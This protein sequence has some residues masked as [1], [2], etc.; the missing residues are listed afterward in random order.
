VIYLTHSRLMVESERTVSDSAAFGEELSR[1]VCAQ[2]L[3]KPA[4]YSLWHARHESGMGMVASARWR[5]RQILRLRAFSLEQV[6]RTALVRYLRD[7][8]VIGACREQTLRDFYGVVD[9]AARTEHRNYILAASSQLCANELLEL[10]GDRAGMSL[11]RSYELAYGQFFG[12]FCEYSRARRNHQRYLLTA[13]IPEVRSAAARQRRRILDGDRLPKV[14]VQS[15]RAGLGVKTSLPM[16]A[17]RALAS[18][19]SA[20]ADARRHTWPQSL[21]VQAMN[22]VRV[23][24]EDARSGPSGSARR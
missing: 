16:G 2:L 3:A 21:W 24:R 1:N 4:R 9:E 13:L 12:M 22:L 18:K 23:P 19:P 15:P 8:R 6:H 14:L 7:H 20:V 10:V 17:N 5:E 11:I